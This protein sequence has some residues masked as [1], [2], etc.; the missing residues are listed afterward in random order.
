MAALLA[1][2]GVGDPSVREITMI[3]VQ[4]RIVERWNITDNA[5]TERVFSVPSRISPGIYFLHSNSPAM[6][7]EKL[8]VR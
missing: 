4:G 3:D 7:P 2:K 1:W 5:S 8:I 6:P